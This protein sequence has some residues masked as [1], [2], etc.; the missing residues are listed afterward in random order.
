MAELEP[1][2]IDAIV[3]DPPYGLEFMGK[4]WDHGVPGVP[5]WTE[6]LRVAKPG[7][8]LLAFGGTRTFHRLA[9]A[10]EDAGWEIRDS[11]AWA[12]GSGFPKSKNL[13]GGFGTA[14]KPAHE[15]IVLAQKP[16]EEPEEWRTILESLTDLGDFLWSLSCARTAASDSASSRAASNA[17]ARVSA[18]WGAGQ[19]SA[20]RAALSALTD[21][22]RSESVI[23]SCLS[24]VS[25]WRD[26]FTAAS[27]ATSTFT[28]ETKSNTTIDPR[29]L[30]SCL[31]AL[32]PLTIIEAAIQE[33]GSWFLASPVA[34]PLSA[35]A[36]SI[37]CTLTLSARVRAIELGPTRLPAG[38]A[39]RVALDAIVLARKPPIGTVAA[40]VLA[41]RTGALN[42][43]GCRIASGADHA[44]KCASVVGLDSNRNGSAYGEGGGKRTDSHSPLGRWPANLVL[45]EPA[46]RML[47]E[48]SGE[49]RTPSTVTRGA[50]DRWAGA[51]LGQQT[52]VPCHGDSGGASRFFYCAKTAGAE[53]NEGV[54]ARNVHPTVKPVALMRWLVRLVTPPDGTVLD[55]FMG[56]GSTG[57]AAKLEDLDFIGIEREPEYL[58][59]ADRRIANANAYAL[60][61]NTPEQP[62]LFGRK[63]ATP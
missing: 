6:A 30:R 60:N 58:E 9:C 35:A 54:E 36:A 19:P 24:I 22:S 44:E 26:A 13:P 57:I 34:A 42:I 16:V 2:S 43:D 14:L 63:G 49:S 33:H 21:T 23:A 8:H 3:T 11:I 40:N 52:G 28:T 41:H 50:S 59:I 53:R 56:S 7:A 48:Q 1:D 38:V 17:A 5:F 45:D 47:D 25:S 12:F 37:V 18:R 61:P 4:E 39:D 62:G 20:T 15:R 32:T 27:E 51:V 55:P 10:I 46:A 31:S 29:T